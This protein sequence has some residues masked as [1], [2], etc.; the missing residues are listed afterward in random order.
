M[1]QDTLDRLTTRLEDSS[2]SEAQR[3]E[4][5]ALV[6]EL[7]R[8]LEGLSDTHPSAA[9]RIAAAVNALATALSNLG[10]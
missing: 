9:E 1:I 5:L 3:A 2:L 6:D 10:V 7:K 4:L 8:E